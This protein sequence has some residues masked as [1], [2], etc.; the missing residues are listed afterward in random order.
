M[1]DVAYGAASCQHVA[2][3]ADVWHDAMIDQPDD[4][5]L[6]LCVGTGGGLFVGKRCEPIP[7]LP[8]P[9]PPEYYSSS[10]RGR[11]A[12]VAWMDVPQVPPRR[13]LG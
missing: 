11:V 8:A 1:R 12:V 13:R 5:R 4:E 7:S 10:R 9:V 6:V 2:G 3:A